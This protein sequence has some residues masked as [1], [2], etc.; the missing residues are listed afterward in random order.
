[1]SSTPLPPSLSAQPPCTHRRHLA[2]V[3]GESGTHRSVA[4]HLALVL[5][6]VGWAGLPQLVLVLGRD[7]VPLLPNLGVFLQV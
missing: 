6:R 3:V 5:E 2:L 1:V 7:S 4:G